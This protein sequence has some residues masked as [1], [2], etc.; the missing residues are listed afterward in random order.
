MNNKSKRKMVVLSINI[1]IIFFSLFALMIYTS[2][3]NE[4]DGGQ[5]LLLIAL[6]PI[7]LLLALVRRI[8]IEKRI[9]SKINALIPFILAVSVSLPVFIDGS[10]SKSMRI[11]GFSVNSLFLIILIITLVIDLKSEYSNVK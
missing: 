4:P 8:E 10:L 9:A 7:F 3:D 6:T 11:I 2:L 1:I 5:F